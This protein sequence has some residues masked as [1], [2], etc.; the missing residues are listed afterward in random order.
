[1]YGH[2]LYLSNDQADRRRGVYSQ[3]RLGQEGRRRIDDRVCVAQGVDSHTGDKTGG[4][5]VV[6]AQIEAGCRAGID[7]WP[8]GWPFI[9]AFQAR[10][11]FGDAMTRTRAFLS[12][13][14][15]T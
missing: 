1:V 13:E 7:I 5:G 9:Y 15:V 4:T 10:R 2:A 8:D 11:H 12:D 14:N 6:Q 3:A